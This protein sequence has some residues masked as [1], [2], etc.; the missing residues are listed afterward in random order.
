MKQIT[1]LCLLLLMILAGCSA[2]DTNS[3]RSL[4]L[5]VTINDQYR[6][7]YDPENLNKTMIIDSF[8]EF[9]A[10]LAKYKPEE[11]KAASLADLYNQEFFK[12]NVL[13]AQA[14][15]VGS[16]STQVTANKVELADE[17][18]KLKIETKTP[19]IG[20]MDMAYWV[21]LFGVDKGV[22]KHIH[23]VEVIIDNKILPDLEPDLISAPRHFQYQSNSVIEQPFDN[24]NPILLQSYDEYKE[25]ISIHPPSKEV[26]ISEK[27]N[28]DYFKNHVVYAQNL[29]VYSGSIKVE[30]R[31][32][33]LVDDTLKLIVN[34]YVP[35]IYTDDIAYWVCMFGVKRSVA[36]L[37][38]VDVLIKEKQTK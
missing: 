35:E 12:H 22:V 27:Y 16:G 7:A 33:Q 32:Y 29:M 5:R 23:G 38:K 11:E 6:T 24:N 28:E 9:N 20:T 30:A 3:P 14:L 31:D 1:V 21:C 36:E 17:T 34:Y 18:L 15:E 37:E 4:S 25:F 26:D 10:F 2:S 8:T 19:N 13:Y